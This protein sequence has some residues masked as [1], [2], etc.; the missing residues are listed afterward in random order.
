MGNRPISNVYQRLGIWLLIRDSLRRNRKRKKIT[1]P[2]HFVT[3][4][5][6]RRKSQYWSFTM[7]I[8]G[9]LIRKTVFVCFLSMFVFSV[10]GYGETRK[11]SASAEHLPLTFEKNVRQTDSQV[12]FLSRAGN[13]RV[14]LT[15]NAAVLKVAGKGSNKYDAVL[16]TTLAGSNCAAQVDGMTCKWDFQLLW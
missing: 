10:S 11:A 4:E 1:L 6:N 2:L 9:K 16:R 3:R 5:W 14:Y 8:S 15:G 7:G 12:R 13:Y